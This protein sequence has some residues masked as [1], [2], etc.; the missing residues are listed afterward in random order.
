MEIHIPNDA[1]RAFIKM[2]V[3]HYEKS[4]S[5]VSRDEIAVKIKEYEVDGDKYIQK[6]K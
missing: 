3:E 1:Q 2:V 5:R 6:I 4:E